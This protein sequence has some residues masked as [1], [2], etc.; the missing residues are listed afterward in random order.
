MTARTPY[1]IGL[2]LVLELAA[3]VGPGS[4][5]SIRPVRGKIAEE[6]DGGLARDRGPGVP[7]RGRSDALTRTP[8]GTPRAPCRRSL[9][10]P[11]LGSGDRRQ[12]ESRAQMG[13]GGRGL[14]RLLETPI[15]ASPSGRSANSKGRGDGQA[16][17]SRRPCGGDR[18]RISY[19]RGRWLPLEASPAPPRYVTPCGI[20]IPATAYKLGD[21]Y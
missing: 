18:G 5:V 19:P 20:A 10:A 9:R 15:A 16:R 12:S 17:G 4:R 3:R 6:L 13:G 21:R 14:G 2:R 8:V 11:L 1:R 7:P